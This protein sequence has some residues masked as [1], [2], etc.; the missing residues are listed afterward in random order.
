MVVLWDWDIAE[1]GRKLLHGAAVFPE[2]LPCV[3]L[4]ARHW[5]SKVSQREPHLHRGGHDLHLH[6]LLGPV[7]GTYLMSSDPWDFFL[8]P[9][10]PLVWCSECVFLA[11][12]E[13]S[14]KGLYF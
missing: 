10:F 4:C 5:G 1:I 7:A 11:L 3:T 8:R 2:H 9:W 14:R 6:A 13:A 12:S